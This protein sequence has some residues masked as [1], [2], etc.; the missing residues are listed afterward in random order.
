MR[1]TGLSRSRDNKSGDLEL[2]AVG[3]AD[4]ADRRRLAGHEKTSA[5]RTRRMTQK[6]TGER[7]ARWSLP[8]FAV[9]GSG[10]RRGGAAGG[11]VDVL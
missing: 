3:A 7:R 5:R 11:F 9:W 1:R 4:E 6:G 10:Q 8:H 2:R